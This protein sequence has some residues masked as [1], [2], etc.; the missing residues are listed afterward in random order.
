MNATLKLPEI[1][2][3]TYANSDWK[4]RYYRTNLDVDYQHKFDN[5]IFDAAVNLGTNNFNYHQFREIPDDIYTLV[6]IPQYTSKQHHSKFS[7]HALRLLEYRMKS[8]P[9]QSVDVMQKRN[10]Q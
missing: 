1:F 2:E 4:S 5:M 8:L 6:A 10:N 7:I 9:L 3:T